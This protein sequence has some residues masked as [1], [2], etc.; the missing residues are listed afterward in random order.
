[1]LH[2]HESEHLNDFER[3]A[4][5]WI[6]TPVSVTEP[7]GSWVEKIKYYYFTCSSDVAHRLAAIKLELER[8]GLLKKP[9]L[10]D[11]ECIEKELRV[12]NEISRFLF[13]CS[14]PA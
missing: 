13:S 4:K 5:L 6:E 12:C 3:I 1:M 9:F 7:D 14:A 8:G 11:Y 10:E 2:D